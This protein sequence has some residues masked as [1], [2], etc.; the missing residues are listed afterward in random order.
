VPPG[1]SS[2]AHRRNG[3]LARETKPP[4]SRPRHLTVITTKAEEV[5]GP[6]R[7]AV[8]RVEAARRPRRGDSARSGSESPAPR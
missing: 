7:A 3:K 6:L 1:E 4:H 5:T 2:T 8:R